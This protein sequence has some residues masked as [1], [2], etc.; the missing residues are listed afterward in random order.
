MK[1]ISTKT[2][3]IL[4][5]LVGLLL[6]A[7]PWFLGFANNGPETWVPVILGVG[8]L[9]YSVF[10][11]Y[12]MGAYRTLSMKTH[13]W[14][15]GIAGLILALSPWLFDFADQVYLPHLIVGVGEV[16][17]ALL[18]DPVSRTEKLAYNDPTGGR[19]TDKG[20]LR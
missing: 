5:Y 12:E 3:G 16:L 2:H 6:I 1:V 19:K 10:T 18:T 17:I 11:D 13:L 9:M 14:I 15:D 7:A 4:D 20:E 8:T